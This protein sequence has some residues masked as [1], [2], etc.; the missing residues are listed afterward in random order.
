[1]SKV[2]LGFAL[3]AAAV[4][5]A[6]SAEE[7]S[8]TTLICHCGAP[9]EAPENTLP[10]YRIA[11][12][13]G[14]GFECDIYLSADKRLFTFHDVDMRRTTGGVHTQKCVE[15]SWADTV[16]KANVGGH[17]RWKG[18]KYDPIRPALLEEVLE[19]AR[20]GRYIYV[21]VK[22]DDPSWVPYIKDVFARQT[23]ATPKNVLFITFGPRL[24]AE[25]KRQ[26]PEYKAYWLTPARRG[27]SV[28][29]EPVTAEYII[30]SLRKTGADG[31]DCQYD[32]EIVTADLVRSVRNAGYEFH[33]WTIDD[34]GSMTEAFA[35]GVQT[36]TTNRAKVLLER[37]EMRH[38]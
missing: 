16:S 34:Y 18:S 17:G 37:Y 2:I 5:F 11:V 1:M 6:A 8:R 30:E 26:M 14:F 7:P 19:L 10:G 12:E 13:R 23:N 24:C 25:L 33:V 22:N 32:P 15:A 9:E 35:R 38:E 4:S 28:G 20:D 36:V 27:W 21:E 3:A 29:T 31:V